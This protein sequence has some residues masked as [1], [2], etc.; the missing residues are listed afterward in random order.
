MLTLRILVGLAAG[1]DPE[2]RLIEVQ[3][4]VYSLIR[5]QAQV[6]AIVTLVWLMVK[7]CPAY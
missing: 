1:L 6:S 7:S 2:A 4:F 5:K 3:C